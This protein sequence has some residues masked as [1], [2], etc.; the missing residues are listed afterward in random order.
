LPEPIP[1][2][3]QRDF[4]RRTLAAEVDLRAAGTEIVGLEEEPQDSLDYR[5]TLNAQ[6]SPSEIVAAGYSW[7]P[8]TELTR[9]VVN[10]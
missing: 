8:G 4:V 1:F 10:L 9:K 5:N 2:E 7:R 6:G 3:S